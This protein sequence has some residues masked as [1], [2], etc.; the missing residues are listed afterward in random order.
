MCDLLVLGRIP[1]RRRI[2]Y[3]YGVVNTTSSAAVDPTAFHAGSRGRPRGLR[4]RGRARGQ[5][6]LYCFELLGTVFSIRTRLLSYPV[7]KTLDILLCLELPYVLGTQPLEFN[8]P[9]ACKSFPVPIILWTHSWATAAGHQYE[10]ERKAFG[11]EST[12]CKE[13]E[14]RNGVFR[15]ARWYGP[16]LEADIPTNPAVPCYLVESRRS[17]ESSVA[18]AEYPTDDRGRSRFRNHN[19]VY[20]RINLTECREP[21]FRGINILEQFWWG[22]SILHL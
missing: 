8:G 9:G 5:S 2:N 20:R 7:W 13:R 11:E 10:V 1:R 19:V 4:A 18:T 22:T 6:V 3:G 21:L 16:S 14:M 12:R 15:H 17:T